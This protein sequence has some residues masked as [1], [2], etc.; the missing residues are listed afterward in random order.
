MHKRHLVMAAGLVV[1]AW[2]AFFGDKTPE[3]DVAEATARPAAPSS[4]VATK[5]STASS[6][7]REQ[8]AAIL[9]LK[10]RENLIGGASASTGADAMFNSHSWTPPP[11][12]PEKPPPPP[13]PRAP[14]LPFTYL[15]KKFEDGEWEVYLGRGDQT[16]IVRNTTIIEGTYGVNAI[17]PP[18]LTLTYLPLNQQQ[19]LTVGGTD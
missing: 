3:S 2:L 10:N 12:P 13:P 5:N 7:S 1:A 19:T 11:P 18:T 9:E 8:M 4:S 17:Q 16:F 6:S 14:A 15:G